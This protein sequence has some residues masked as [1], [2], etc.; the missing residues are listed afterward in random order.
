MQKSKL[1]TKIGI[2]LLVSL[3]QSV[4]TARP[5]DHE[6][7]AAQ[8]PEASNIKGGL[9]V[10]IG[11][12][13]GELTAALRKNDSYLVHGLDSDRQKVRRAREHIQSLGI[14]GNVSVD[15]FDGR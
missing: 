10:H 5:A 12:G 8:I 13:G 1:P 2:V 7:E 9:I 11:C 14:Y 4:A 15:M 6:R 3:I